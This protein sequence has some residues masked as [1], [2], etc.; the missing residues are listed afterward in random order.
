MQKN[1]FSRIGARNSTVVLTSLIK[2]RGIEENIL[3]VSLMLISAKIN[4]IL[5]NERLR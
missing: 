1:T 4:S 5:I 2:W 3:N